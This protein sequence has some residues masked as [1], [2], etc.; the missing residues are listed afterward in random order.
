MISP[1]IGFDRASVTAD[2]TR[3]CIF[4]SL[5]LAVSLSNDSWLGSLPLESS[6]GPYV[7]YLLSDLLISSTFLLSTK[8][9]FA[10]MIRSLSLVL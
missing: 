4:S 3:S 6:N 2:R 8:L 1:P 10:K 9:N 5:N 7:E